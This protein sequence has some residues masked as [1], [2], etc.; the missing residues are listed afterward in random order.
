[1]L[2]ATTK[3]NFIIIAVLISVFCV[4]NF[5]IYTSKERV[6]PTK[7]SEK[8]LKGQ[9]LWQNNNCWSCHQIY[10][11]GGYLGP[12]LTNIYSHPN[13]GEKYIKALLN[14]GIKSM[15][16]FNFSDI[17]KDALIAFF[18][19]I[20]ETGYYPNLEAVIKSNGWVELKYKDEK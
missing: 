1:M 6:S 2:K 13:K 5:L 20:D 8:A 7:L 14:S 19:Q 3:N 16:K 10:G 4:Y 17:E 11:L 18:K 12:D 15:P 9:V